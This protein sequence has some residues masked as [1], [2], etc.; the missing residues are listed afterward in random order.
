MS[1]GLSVGA[2]CSLIFL[3]VQNGHKR[4]RV[5]K[6]MKGREENEN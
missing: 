1:D 3:I 5:R 2:G 6:V 4:E